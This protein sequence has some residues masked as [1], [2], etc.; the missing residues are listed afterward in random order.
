MQALFFRVP[1]SEAFVLL[2]PAP[3]PLDLRWR[4]FGVRVRVH[5]SFWLFALLFGW[6]LARAGAGHVAIWVACMF[7]SILVHE[8]GHVTA[9]RCFGQSAHVVLYSFGGLAI[10]AWQ[11]LRN[12]QRM[13]IAL[14]GP[15]AGFA[16]YGLVLALDHF[17]LRENLPHRIRFHEAYGTALKSLLYMNLF[18]NALNLIP[19]LP[20]DGGQFLREVLMLGSFPA[21]GYK[22][23]LG[24]SFV[25]AGLVALYSG[26][27]AA[28]NA[29]E[30][31]AE[32]DLYWPTLPA[33]HNP[34]LIAYPP[35]VVGQLTEEQ[36][37]IGAYP[38]VMAIFFALM[39]IQNLL[40]FRETERREKRYLDQ[41]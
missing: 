22:A 8:L 30:A 35:G 18:W 41:E 31:P 21:R 17:Y 40:T 1:V 6:P 4:M 7:V 32:T 19:V 29:P 26:L 20:L 33:S 24:V 5:P 25:V 23:A 14:G 34:F 16:L 27:V 15:L 39:G 11:D 10:G 9:S 36:R 13:V 28:R 3:S 37:R 2:E 38:P 12:W